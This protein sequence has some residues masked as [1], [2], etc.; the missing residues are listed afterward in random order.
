AE[1]RMY[2]PLAALVVLFVVGG[3]QLA[4]SISLR[5]TGRRDAGPAFRPITIA[6]PMFVIAIACG[7]ASAKRLEAYQKPLE[8]WQQ[9]LRYQPQND[10][11]H[12]PIG[13]YFDD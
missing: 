3:Y 5:R 10:T 11:A 12:N 2:L 9:V 13:K 4:K 6:F 1:R 8:L 7:V